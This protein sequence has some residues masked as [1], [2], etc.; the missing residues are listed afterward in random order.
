[1]HPLRYLATLLLAASPLAAQKGLPPPTTP[2]APV[3]RHDDLVVARA[4][5][6]ELVVARRAMSEE[7]RAALRHLAE[8]KLLEAFGR[9]HALEPSEAEV[10]ARMREIDAAVKQGGDPRGLV[11]QMEKVRL[12]R[13]QFARFLRLGIVHERATRR[14]LNLPDSTPVSGDQQRLWIEE[15]LARRG[16]ESRPPPWEDGV[17]AKGAG[18]SIAPAEFLAH[19]LD[20]LPRETL[21]DDSRQL[22]LAKAMRRRM[23]DLA[24]E[25]LAKAV[26]DELARRRAEVARDPRYKGVPYEELLAA[27]GVQAASLKHDPGIVSTALARLW[28]ERKWSPADLERVYRD[29]RALFDGRHG[30]AID[31]RMLFLRAAKFKNEL[32]PRNFDEATAALADLKS[33]I[34]GIEDFERF[35]RE[36][37][38]DAASR[39]QGGRVGW[40]A[41]GAEKLPPELSSL[42][43]EVL[44]IPEGQPGA[45]GLA[46][47]VR[48]SNGMVLLWLGVRRPAPP[49][50]QMALHVQAELRRRF[51][52]SCL[53]KSGVETAFEP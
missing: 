24:P 46:G 50:P 11:G 19:L 26:E 42:V 22:L 37:S 4:E 36:R 10:E 39:E 48:V 41:P 31:A 17:V 35:A 6:E 14:A 27:Q 30:P 44:A 9:E 8:S 13:E 53:P 21:R 3:A 29:E 51:V 7:G 52:D 45:Q 28:I 2:D 32:N 38:E 40:V 12:T 25:S 1:M 20:R 15:E 34:R 23:P 5:L 18:F 47:P 33:R 16:F 43:A 49:W